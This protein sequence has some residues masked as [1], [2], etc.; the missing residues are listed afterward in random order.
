[1]A[2]VNKRLTD[3]VDHINK[4]EVV[5]QWQC[6]PPDQ[7][8]YVPHNQRS[9]DFNGNPKYIY[10]SINTYLIAFDINVMR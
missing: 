2:C 7:S 5:K 9:D 3:T 8:L 1:M 4:I 10:F 6:H